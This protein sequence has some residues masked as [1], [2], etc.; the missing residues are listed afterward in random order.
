METD[1]TVALPFLPT[2]KQAIKQACK[3]F[4]E[5]YQPILTQVE[6]HL[7]QL[8]ENTE[9]HYAQAYKPWLKG[10]RDL[11][12]GVFLMSK[13]IPVPDPAALLDALKMFSFEGALQLL[14]DVCI[15][16]KIAI[17][18]DWIN[19]FRKD[20]DIMLFAAANLN[21]APAQQR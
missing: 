14:N 13:S 16:C 10:V 21:T 17:K 11:C 12:M 3:N 9:P 18:S 2:D 7:K 1:D 6:T 19:K 20:I 8:M 4:I 5:E 15:I